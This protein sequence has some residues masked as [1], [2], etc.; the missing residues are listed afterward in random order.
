MRLP[1]IPADRRVKWLAYV[2]FSAVAG[3]TVLLVVAQWDEILAFPWRLHW[4]YLALTLLFSA[5]SLGVTFVVWHLMIARLT[6]AS[7]WRDDFRIYY[8]STLAKRVPTS[9]PFIGSRLMMYAQLGVPATVVLNCILLET[10]LIGIGGVITFLA[11]LPLYSGMP[12]VAATVAVPGLALMALL[13]LRPGLFIALSNRVSKRLGRPPLE[14]VPER[15]DILLWTALY[16][17]PWLLAGA[18]F[19]SVPR[20]F[21]N[22]SAPG[23][24]D[25][26]GIS[27]L[28]MLIALFSIIMPS[29]LGL[30][31]VASGALLSPWMPFSTAVLISLAYR[32]LQ[33]G[34]EMV[35]ATL[36]Y[37]ATKRGQ[38][39]VSEPASAPAIERYENKEPEDQPV[40]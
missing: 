11:L 27:T 13:L 7:R 10:V 2:L 37:V 5:L 32:L 6:G 38:P 16:V 36:A 21:S 15:R 17:A 35:M 26:I 3:L 20:A 24:V 9:L 40:S 29:G 31:E 8:V 34:N 18:A 4:G 14:R 23:L 28:T 33:T 22:G 19:Y 25:A 39:A 1:S 30:K 12:A